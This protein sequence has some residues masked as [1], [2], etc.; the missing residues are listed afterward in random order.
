MKIVPIASLALMTS[1]VL[2][3]CAS[4]P[5]LEDQTKLV[6]YEMCLEESLS[7]LNRL[8]DAR[9]MKTSS[10]DWT[11]FTYAELG[12]IYKMLKE[13]KEYRP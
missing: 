11:D 2:T 3:G 12:G 1:L 13:C 7:R 8:I 9:T 6:E 5:T 10:T 4:T